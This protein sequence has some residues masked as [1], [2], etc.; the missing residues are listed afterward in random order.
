MTRWLAP[1]A[2]LVVVIGCDQTKAPAP[3]V[4]ATTAVEAP[5]VPTPEIVG[6]AELRETQT[7]VI[8]QVLTRHGVRAE[9]VKIRL[10]D[11]LNLE[12]TGPTGTKCSRKVP[13][14]FVPAEL[15]TNF[16]H[17]L[18]HCLRDVTPTP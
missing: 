3:E 14:A 5:K 11:A 1:L 15:V 9:S 4:A 13:S 18:D 7:Q 8:E 6:L 10:D 16:D 17:T 2:F 12:V